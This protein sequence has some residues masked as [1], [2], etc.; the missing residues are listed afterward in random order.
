[1]AEAGCD[2]AITGRT[3]SYLIYTSDRIRATGR[4]CLWAKADV[5]KRDDVKDFVDQVVTTF[6]RIDILVN[7]A[8]ITIIKPLFEISEEE[9]DGLV[10][11]NL[12]SVFLMCKNVLPSMMSQSSGTI[13]NV[14][15]VSGRLGMPR[16][17]V[18]SATKAGV[19][20]LSESLGREVGRGIRV[21][22]VCPGGV[23][24][25]MNREVPPLQRAFL[26]RPENVA[27]RI[28]YLCLND[29]VPSGTCIDIV[30]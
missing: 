25:D 7:N 15:S 8:G 3:E 18:Y 23:D 12:K 13:I 11:T 5:S 28:L 2:V 20:R 27:E 22:G 24:T 16:L 30:R 14:A 6:R 1:M 29:N 21:Y 9:W 26:L 10:D 19:M 4:D 17:S